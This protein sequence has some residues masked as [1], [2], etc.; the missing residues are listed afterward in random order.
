M[1]YLGIGGIFI[2]FTCEANVNATLP[3]WEI[4]FTAAHELAHQRGFAREEEANYVGYLACRAHPDR[5]F[6]YSGTFRAALYALSALGQ[7]DRAAYGRMRGRVTAP[8]G[9]DLA[10]LAAWH[11]RY[12]P[13]GGG[14]GAGQ[15]RLPQ[16]AG[17]SGRRAQ[18]RTDGG[19][20]AGRAARSA[21]IGASASD[22]SCDVDEP[23]QDD[24]GGQ[25]VK[26]ARVGLSGDGA[27]E[28]EHRRQ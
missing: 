27:R 2:P 1:S 12:E 28:H 23:G 16:D 25:D 24:G 20:V 21:E 4:P 17:A 9:R 5:D 11:R 6:Q 13:P 14:A 15:R 18:L 8:L 3:D 10:A 22:L 26:P 19:L 7:V